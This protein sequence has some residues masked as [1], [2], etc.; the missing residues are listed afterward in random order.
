MQPTNEVLEKKFADPKMYQF[1]IRNIVPRFVFRSLSVIVATAFAA[2][3]PF[4]G[5]IMAIMGAFGFIPLDFIFPMIVYN[6]TFKPSKR[7]LVF[8]GNT[9]IAVVSGVLS[10]IGAIASVRQTVLDA[11]HYRLFANI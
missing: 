8:W 9:F 4:F 10:A 3:L 7:G 2:M 1:S 6:V 5:D 11:K